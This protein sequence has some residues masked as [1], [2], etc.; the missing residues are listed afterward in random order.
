MAPS[1]L[2]LEFELHP[3]IN[4]FII[5]FMFGTAPVFVGTVLASYFQEYIFR[6]E[7]VLF[8]LHIAHFLDCGPE[9]ELSYENAQVHLCLWTLSTSSFYLLSALSSCSVCL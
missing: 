4:V 2:H 1:I 9:S 5:N 8:L 6:V 3:A 7:E